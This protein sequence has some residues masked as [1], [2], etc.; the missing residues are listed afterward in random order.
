M[1]I[2]FPH[3]KIAAALACGLFAAASAHADIVPT[4]GLPNT[5]DLQYSTGTFGGYNTFTGN[6]GAASISVSAGSLLFNTRAPGTTAPLGSFAAYCVELSQHA[7]YAWNTYTLTSFTPNVGKS[8]AHL[9]QV[10]GGSP[11]NKDSS[12]AFQAA[13]WEITHETA[14]GAYSLDNGSFNGT[15]ITKAI[16]TQANTWLATVNDFSGPE[17]YKAQKF[18]SS[19]AQDQLVITAVPEPESYALLLAGL[20]LMGT[21]ARRRNKRNTD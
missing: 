16:T 4:T 1:K 5:I 3:S 19:V 17:L 18:A 13:V 11:T 9:Y 15:F 7:Q 10:A 21:I 20:G 12:A 6:N 14:P 2:H 8:L